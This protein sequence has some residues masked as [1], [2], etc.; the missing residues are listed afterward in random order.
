MPR[1][2]GT[3]PRGRGPLTGQGGGFCVMKVP[4]APGEPLTGF[5]G[6]S[7][8]PVR[9][10]PVGAAPWGGFPADRMRRIESDIRR[11]RRRIEALRA[12]TDS[13]DDRRS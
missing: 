7:G 11:L 6:R 13:S 3:G 9:L 4:Q 12:E 1:Y 5:A 10:D 2:D 8:I